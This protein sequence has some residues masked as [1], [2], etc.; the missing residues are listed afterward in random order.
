MKR[1]FA[2][3]SAT[4]LLTLALS[5]ALGMPSAE[6]S[7]GEYEIGERLAPTGQKQTGSYDSIT[8]DDLIPPDWLSQEWLDSLNVDDFEDDDPRAAEL[9]AVIMEK[10]N[11]APVVE[12]IN[13]RKGR[14]AGFV[15]PLEGD[16]RHIYEFL[17][18]PYFGACIHVPPPPANQ[19][20]HVLPDK[21]IPSQWLMTAVWVKGTFE[22][23]RL[24]SDLGSAGY[25]LQAVEVEEFLGY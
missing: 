22:V 11:Q 19:I 16:D 15:V 3:L 23:E 24:D 5:L 9:L 13:G 25:R 7:S 6:T 20:I 17:L 1:T 21:P 18:V 10:W 2:S 8:W 12:E 14:I 4:F